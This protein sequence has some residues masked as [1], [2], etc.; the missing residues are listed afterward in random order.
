M[1]YKTHGLLL[2]TLSLITSFTVARATL[3][4]VIHITLPPGTP[5]A[6][7]AVTMIPYDETIYNLAYKV[8][9][10]NT[11]IRDAYALAASAVQQTQHKHLPEQNRQWRDKLAQVSIWMQ[12]PGLAAQQY[13]F[14]AQQNQDNRALS[15]GI[16]IT[17]LM[18]DDLFL[19]KFLYIALQK[20]PDSESVTKQ[21][22]YALLRLGEIEPAM[23]FL[24]QHATHYTRSFYWLF[25]AQIHALVSDIDAQLDAL[26]QHSNTYG[27]KP[28]VAMK[29]ALIY[30][31]QQNIKQAEHV[32][33]LAQKNALKA[34]RHMTH[35]W[36]ALA[37]LSW[38]TNQTHEEK[39]A[40][41]QLFHQKKS[42][43]NVYIHLIDLYSQSDPDIAYHL[44][45]LSKQAY[46]NNISRAVDAFSWCISNDAWA[47][48]PILNA[49]TPPSVLKMI[50]YDPSYGE[51]AAH[52][53]QSI[54][55]HERAVNRYL[56]TIDTLPT[57]QYL[58]S[59]FIYFLI[60]TN[61]LLRLAQVFSLWINKDTF[62][63]ILW[64]GF[65]EGSSLLNHEPMKRLAL[66]LFYEHLNENQYDPYWLINFKDS[67]ESTYFPEQAW[68]IAHEAWSSYIKLL[69]AQTTPVDYLQLINYIKLSMQEAPGDKTGEA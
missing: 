63:T 10:L 49:S 40:Y 8:Y 9:L 16:A 46:P 14:V 66:Q 57:N 26:T 65:A 62:D 32:L 5:G 54:N 12:N 55:Q 20:N 13:L 59:D 47:D 43:E 48:F 23:S 45:K 44:A 33:M 69:V 42:S 24:N 39:L 3:P 30:V 36:E 28:S 68:A 21:I 1:S 41:Q 4:S 53:L 60:Q 34:S 27:M 19:L 18:H 11:N 35:F 61:D 37:T 56:Q 50:Q 29:Q 15:K 17:T 7:Q 52:Y 2:L 38:L 64:A 67:L 31:A 58:K 51:V 22:L 25:K 6:H